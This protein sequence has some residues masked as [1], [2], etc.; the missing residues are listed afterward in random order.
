[1][2]DWTRQELGNDLKSFGHLF[3]FTNQP[4]PPEPKDLWLGRWYTPDGQ[5]PISLLAD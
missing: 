5:Q 2:R 4:Q 1:M 3:L